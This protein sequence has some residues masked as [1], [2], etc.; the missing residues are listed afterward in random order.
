MALEMDNITFSV[1]QTTLTRMSKK[2]GEQIVL[3]DEASVVPSGAVRLI[4]LQE[5][6]YAYLRP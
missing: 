1:C 6:D 4:E 5:N 3:M 2:V